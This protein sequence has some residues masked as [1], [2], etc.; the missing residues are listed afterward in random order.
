[1]SNIRICVIS[2]VCLAGWVARQLA[3]YLSFVAD[4]LMLNIACKLFN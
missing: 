4:T 1:M 2:H 3:G